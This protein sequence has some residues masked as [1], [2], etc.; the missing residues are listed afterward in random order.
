MEVRQQSQVVF[1]H[2][3]A[4]LTLAQIRADE[5]DLFAAVT[6]PGSFTG[7][8]I[9]L[10]AAEGIAAALEKPVVGVTTFDASA[11]ATQLDGP[12]VTLVDAGRGEV[13]MGIREMDDSDAPRIIG[14]DFV[15]SLEDAL[16]TARRAMPTPG[17]ACLTGSACA[18][19]HG[20]I[21]LA[22]RLLGLGLST[23]R[24]V[25]RDSSVWHLD[26]HATPLAPATAELASK[27]Y[28]S[29]HHPG[30]KPYYL[31]P[32]DAEAKWKS[33]VTQS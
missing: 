14:Q 15:G 29:G 30:L 4:L 8:R 16:D 18:R 26:Q 24:A 21:L 17:G 7:L 3:Q 33:L 20:P 12:I 28:L 6:G 23:S 9:G 22:A 11:V 32:S 2:L 31:K 19:H 27:W 10:A 5:I 1:E 25:S 13:F